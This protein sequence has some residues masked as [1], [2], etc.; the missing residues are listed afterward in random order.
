MNLIKVSG[1]IPVLIP[2]L[3]ENESKFFFEIAKKNNWLLSI[4]DWE[5]TGAK[6]ITD[7]VKKGGLLYT[8]DAVMKGTTRNYQKAEIMFSSKRK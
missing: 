8:I 4:P 1:K 3:K 7:S 2:D 5:S 6:D